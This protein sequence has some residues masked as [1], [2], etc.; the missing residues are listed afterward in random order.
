MAEVIHLAEVQ[1]ARRRSRARAP[2]RA[3]LEQAVKVLRESLAATAQELMD[4]PCEEQD[5]LLQ[6]VERL[7]A[8]I[9]Y[10]LRMLGRSSDPGLD[11]ALPDE[12]YR[13]E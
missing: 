10:G 8:L 13:F 2:D 1:A 11:R 6:R 5:E 9:R 3:E 7:A 4:A 12:S